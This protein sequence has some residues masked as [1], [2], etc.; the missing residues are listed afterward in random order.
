M[1]KYKFLIF[2]TGVVGSIFGTK[3]QKAGNDVLF[4]CREYQEV[5]LKKNGIILEPLEIVKFLK[6]FT[7]MKEKTFPINVSSRLP[8]P[9]DFDY[10]ILSV[11]FNQIDNA[12]KKLKSNGLNKTPV[13][14]LQSGLGEIDTLIGNIKNL[15]VFAP[16]LAGYKENGIIKYFLP[17]FVPT[18]IGT[19]DGI[20]IEHIE[21]LEFIFRSSKI[22]V[23]I[24]SNILSFIPFTLSIL[25]PLTYAIGL[26]DYSLDY[27]FKDKK[28][29]KKA[30][31]EIK[32]K[33]NVLSKRHNRYKLLAL[34]LRL[35]PVFILEFIIRFG[36]FVTYKK[37]KPM[38]ENYSLSV[39][40]QTKILLDALHF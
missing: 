5:D 27:L 22:P 14:A 4:Y 2:G 8:N 31:V 3:L 13:V 9:E 38:V 29:L 33:F 26:A 34:L 18:V 15:I 7:D 19:P 40:E 28:L 1:A 24:S 11:R 17:F 30:I 35:C 12:I 16:G 25:V 32:V 23:K 6:G 37:I 39:K 20:I 36:I 21:K 10:I